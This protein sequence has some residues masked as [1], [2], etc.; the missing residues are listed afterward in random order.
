MTTV[1]NF[2]LTSVMVSS[3]LP[4]R[5]ICVVP[6]DALSPLLPADGRGKIS[7]WNIKNRPGT[8][9][10]GP[11][12]TGGENDFED[13]AL[14]NESYSIF[15]GSVKSF[16]GLLF[17]RAG[18]ANTFPGIGTGAF[19]SIGRVSANSRNAMPLRGE[20]PVE[21]AGE[22]PCAREAEQ[23]GG[24][25]PPPHPEKDLGRGLLAGEHLPGRQD[26]V[27]R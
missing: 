23:G 18:S 11:G 5:I 26:P 16:P 4:V 17:G 8:S 27:G 10:R 19:P 3:L 25:P 24:P 13:G 12:D 9:P 20:P 6:P 21:G 1:S 7:Q 22:N 2:H 15:T 14:W